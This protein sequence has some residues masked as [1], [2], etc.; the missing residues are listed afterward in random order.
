VNPSNDYWFTSA[1]PARA[2]LAKTRFRAIETRR[3]IV[4]A[5]STGYSAL[6]DPRG[7]LAASSGF[8]GAEWLAGSVRGADGATLHQR[9]GGVLGP[10]ALAACFALSLAH[11]FRTTSV[12]GGWRA[13]LRM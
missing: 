6:I 7:D 9:I 1:A 13:R 5:T 4:R 10:G 8:G 2:Q 3:W 11:R 12:S